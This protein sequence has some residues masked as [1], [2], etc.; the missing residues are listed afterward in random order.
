MKNRLKILFIIIAGFL[1]SEINA[2]SI[3][4]LEEKAIDVKK[5]VRHLQIQIDSLSVLLTNNNTKISQIKNS[6]TLLKE[7][8]AYSAEV[9]EEIKTRTIIIKGLNREF[10]DIRNLL[11]K[12]ITDQLSELKKT[13]N[14]DD[15]IQLT[16]KQIIY[17]PL[18]SVLK[19]KPERLLN[20]S[21]SEMEDSLSLNLFK[22]TLNEAIKE[23]KTHLGKI[24]VI[25]NEYTQITELNKMA[26]EFTEEIEFDSD[27]SRFS[28]SVSNRLDEI[29]IMG[30]PNRGDKSGLY[31][32]LVGSNIQ[33]YNSILTQLDIKEVGGAN[34]NF[35]LK[36]IKNISF[37]N[38]FSYLRDVQ[39]VL[40]KY[41]TILIEKRESLN[42]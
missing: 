23:V 17:A 40:V 7:I 24:E 34:R 32:D 37:S 10:D 42:D 26:N 28:K 30:S 5:Q 38:Y 33:G 35:F 39:K 3:E 4:Q 8:L 19:Y 9:S 2:Q 18:I 22:E 11:Y 31:S 25:Q 41:K 36:P 27:I 15:L 21:L 20:Y 13:E 6:E 16:T 12:K 14:Q 1:F 29:E